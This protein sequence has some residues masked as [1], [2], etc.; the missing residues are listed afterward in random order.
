MPTTT[1][2]VNG[3]GAII[4][5]EDGTE[6]VVDISGSANEFSINFDNT[7]GD[8][9]VFGDANTYRMEC[10]R[11]ASIDL[12][13]LYSTGTG[14]GWAVLKQWRAVR[15]LRAVTITLGEDVYSA[16]VYW[17]KISLGAKSDEATPVMVKATLKPNGAV[18]IGAVPVPEPEPEGE[19]SGGGGE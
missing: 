17:E 16:D 3:C 13:I 6:A 14:E 4:T 5:L 8:Y 11:D 9:K 15:G 2:T 7:L 18:T 19:G 10:G 12:T 1:S